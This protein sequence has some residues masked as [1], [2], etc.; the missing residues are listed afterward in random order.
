MRRSLGMRVWR[1]AIGVLGV[2]LCAC[3]TRIPVATPV[4]GQSFRGMTV[5]RVSMLDGRT[6]EVWY[7]T[8]SGDTSLLGLAN[9][10]VHPSTPTVRIPIREIRTIEDLKLNEPRSI[11]FLVLLTAGALVLVLGTLFTIVGAPVY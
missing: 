6:Q 8:V 9:K 11:V 1:I 3:Y 7:P 10:L 5:V 2:L 4:H